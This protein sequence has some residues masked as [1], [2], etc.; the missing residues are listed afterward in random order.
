[1][2][3]RKY[4]ILVLGNYRQTVT[5][6]RSLGRAG[7]NVILGRQGEK[8]YTEYSRYVAEVWPHPH[9]VSREQEFL[10]AL[11]CLLAERPDIRLV[12]P[13]GETQIACIARHLQE[14]A[15]PGCFV[16]PDPGVFAA[17]ADKLHMHDQ[18]AC[19]DIPS[20]VSVAV[21]TRDELVRAIDRI[22]YPCVVKPAST[23]AR[24][25]DFKALIFRSENDVARLLPRWPEGGG[26][27]VLQE[28]VAG[29]RHNCHFI[30]IDGQVR[31][32]FEQRVLRTD[33]IDGTG[34]GVEGISVAPDQRLRGH[35]ERLIASLGYSGAGCIQFLVDDARGTVSF[36][37]V[38]PR[39]DATC[40]VPYCCDY[41]F[42][43]MAVQCAEY[44]LGIT[45][46]APQ[47]LSAYPAGRVGVWLFGDLQGLAEA[48]NAKELTPVPALLWLGRIFGSLGRA[49]F[50]LVWS[51]R[52]PLPA[53]FEYS[54]LPAA[55]LSHAAAI[56]RLFLR[57]VLPHGRRSPY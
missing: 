49:D 52:D 36:L 34:Y 26:S 8:A 5:V 40:A 38:N 17:C 19:L 50:H 22:G 55:L 32:Y 54:C 47:N 33:R 29:M 35:C 13:V 31:A 51:W 7:Y 28:C 6:V 1:V 30:A 41:D 24:T 2:R 56:P 42:P 43:R 27:L 39:L 18:V 4:S 3:G 16:M 15:Q 10:T 20:A 21:S 12:F 25:V 48:W 9:L 53:L 57:W 14:F 23:L 44:R 11:R 45:R 37:E 46:Q